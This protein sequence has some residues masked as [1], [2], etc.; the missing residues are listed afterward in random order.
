[1]QPQDDAEMYDPERPTSD[2]DAPDFADRYSELDR[3]SDRLQDFAGGAYFWH[4]S[5]PHC[6]IERSTGE[7]T[8]ADGQG[9]GQYFLKVNLF[10]G[11]ELAYGNWFYLVPT[12]TG[13]WDVDSYAASEAD[14]SDESIY[15]PWAHIMQHS[16]AHMTAF[17]IKEAHTFW[18][19]GTTE[20]QV[21][22]ALVADLNATGGQNIAWVDDNTIKT[23]F[24]P[25]PVNAADKYT[26]A[27]MSDLSDMI[28][29][30]V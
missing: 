12:A 9:T 2:D 15:V 4:R 14:A 13:G 20:A 29:E 18:P 17:D 16:Y 7:F 22:G 28:G 23:F 8:T 6:Y 19:A 27:Q 30:I 24:L 26:A 11:D 21:L 25:G 10:T 3:A 1:M 5:A